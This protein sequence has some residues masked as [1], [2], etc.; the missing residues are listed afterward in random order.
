MNNIQYKIIN[1]NLKLIKLN[2]RKIKINLNINI[3]E[4]GQNLNTKNQM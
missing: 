4:A 2:K 3:M 1:L